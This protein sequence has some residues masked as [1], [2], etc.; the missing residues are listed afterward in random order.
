[1]RVLPGHRRWLACVCTPAIGTGSH[2]HAAPPGP[3]DECS[4]DLM[5]ARNA[6]LA[7]QHMHGVPVAAL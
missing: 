3:C 6:A 4:V 5:P 2:V 1:M 7:F